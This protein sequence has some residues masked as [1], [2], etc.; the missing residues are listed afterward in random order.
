MEEK[1]QASATQ[2]VN[3]INSDTKTDANQNELQAHENDTDNNISSDTKESV[4]ISQPESGTTPQLDNGAGAESQNIQPNNTNADT[5]QSITPQTDTSVQETA[6]SDQTN[7][8]NQPNTETV[9]PPV[10]P[11][12][13]TPV[14]P[15]ATQQSKRKTGP[16]R[17]QSLKNKIVNQIIGAMKNDKGE[18]LYAVSFKEEP[19]PY[20]IPSH[21]MKEWFPREL[22]D[23][24]ESNVEIVDSTSSV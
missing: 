2:P 13:K 10:P 6:E 20:F 3:Q 4:S 21:Q 23:F 17:L 1:S 9:Q 18:I 14:K 19:M 22:A 11:S 24:L 15:T 16:K 5:S 12:A 8:T 7:K